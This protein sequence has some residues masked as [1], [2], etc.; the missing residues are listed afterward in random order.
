MKSATGGIRSVRERLSI[1][2]MVDGDSHA[3]Y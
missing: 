2:A 1:S 3:T